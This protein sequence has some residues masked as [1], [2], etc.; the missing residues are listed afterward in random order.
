MILFWHPEVIQTENVRCQTLIN[1]LQNISAINIILY[2]YA[3][4]MWLL[5]IISLLK[6][7]M[8]KQDFHSYL[9]K[10]RLMKFQQVKVFSMQVW[11]LQLSRSQKR[12]KGKIDFI[13]LFSDLITH[14]IEWMVTDISCIHVVRD[15]LFFS[16]APIPTLITQ[17]LY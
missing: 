8:V 5:C 7:E 1:Y 11:Q 13:K 17:K 2:F 9:F 3:Y 4:D 12:W 10:N 6:E 15:C 16:Q 14:T